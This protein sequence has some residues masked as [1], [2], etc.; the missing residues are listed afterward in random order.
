MPKAQ[1]V[2]SICP[3]G[4]TVAGAVHRYYGSVQTRVCDA[5]PEANANAVLPMATTP[6]FDV[7][8]HRHVTEPADATHALRNA[9]SDA[10]QAAD[11][12]REGPNV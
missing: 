11:M 5:S 9:S 6:R 2:S 1:T 12:V 8:G 10:L 3:D 7:T 4:T